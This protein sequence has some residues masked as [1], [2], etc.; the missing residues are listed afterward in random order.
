MDKIR[1]YHDLLGHVS[2]YQRFFLLESLE[3][4]FLT[5]LDFERKSSIIGTEGEKAGITLDS[6]VIRN[7]LEITGEMIAI[8]KNDT[9]NTTLD[10]KHRLCIRHEK[11]TRALR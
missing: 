10:G 11:G 3:M 1:V 5:V 9:A 6:P 8:Y 4:Q 7:P 2:M